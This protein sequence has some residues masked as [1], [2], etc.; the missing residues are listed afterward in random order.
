MRFPFYSQFRSILIFLPGYFLMLCTVEGQVTSKTEGAAAPERTTITWVKQWPSTD[1]KQ[2]QKSFRNR[3]NE[4]FLGRKNLALIRPVAVF[5]ENPDDFWVLDQEAGSLF[6]VEQGVGDIPH[7]LRKKNF[8][9]SSLVGICSNTAGGLLFTDSFEKKIFCLDPGNKQV[10]VL[11]DT[12]QLDQPTGIAYFAATNEI[13]VAETNAH[14][15]TVLNDRG[16]PV[17]RI[18]KRGTAPGE[19]NFP[20]N[21][22]IGRNG[23]VYVVDA[24]NFRVQ[25]FSGSGELVSVFGKAGDAS[26]Y[27]ARPK[28]IATDSQGNIYVVDGLFHAVQVFDIKGNLL[29]NLGRQGQGEGEFWMPSGIFIDD[30]DFI[31]VSDSYNSR[32]Q[33]FKPDHQ[34]TKN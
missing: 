2:K 23:L 7:F 29:F 1:N 16:V 6:Q 10:K 3:F 33:V 21:I 28:G 15:L 11:N 24:M 27:F 25:V 34:K 12:L 18:G 26:G 19:F 9:T 32:V 8:S 14:R 4:I 31:Y 22:W 13:W 30:R 17:R 5:A 20:T